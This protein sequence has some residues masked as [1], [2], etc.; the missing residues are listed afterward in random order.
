MK[1]EKKNFDP[2]N[3]K[4][5]TIRLVPPPSTGVHRVVMNMDFAS[6]YPSTMNPF[7]EE[8]IRKAKVKQRKDKLKE[9][10]GDEIEI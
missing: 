9:I 4:G 6:L 5:G 3:Y 7:G 10:F 2:K 1:K 8:F